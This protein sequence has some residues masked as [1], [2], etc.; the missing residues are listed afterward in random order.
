MSELR[1]SIFGQLQSMN[2]IHSSMPFSKLL[3]L[4]WNVCLFDDISPVIDDLDVVQVGLLF[5][6]LQFLL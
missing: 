2:I 3:D 6:R 4:L 5:D 1:K